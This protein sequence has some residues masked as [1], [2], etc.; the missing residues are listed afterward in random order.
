VLGHNVL[1]ACWSALLRRYVW[2]LRGS[3][4]GPM[5]MT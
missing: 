2:L 5:P 4:A 1:S 3:N